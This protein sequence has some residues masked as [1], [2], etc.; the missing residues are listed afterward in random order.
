MTAHLSF[1]SWLPK[2]GFNLFLFDY[3]G[4]GASEGS[5]E[6]KGIYQDCIAALEYIKSRKD[7]NPNRLLVFGQSLGGANALFLIGN[8]VKTIK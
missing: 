6:R 2:E 3:R 8:G 7:I 5:P 4:Y 1:V